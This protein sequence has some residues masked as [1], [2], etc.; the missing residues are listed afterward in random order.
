VAIFSAECEGPSWDGEVVQIKLHEL[1]VHRLRQWG[2]CWLACQLGDQ[3]ELEAYGAPRLPPR[4]K[5]SRWRHVLKAWVCYRLIDPGSEWRWHRR[6]YEH[7][8]MAEL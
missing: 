7:S 2:A 6:W 4:R 3:L 8:A 1:Q 5:G